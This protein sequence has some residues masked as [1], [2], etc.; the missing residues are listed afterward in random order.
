MRSPKISLTAAR[1][2]AALTQKEFAKKCGVCETTVI[3]WELGR[4]LPNVNMLRVIETALGYPA[5][6][7]RFEKIG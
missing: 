7:I 1:V 6:L 3:N 5:D 4:R 2:N